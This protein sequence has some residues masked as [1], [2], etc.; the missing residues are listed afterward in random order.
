LKKI[1]FFIYLLASLQS[2]S[3]N[4]T[5]GSVYNFDVGD[6]IVTAYAPY[7][8]GSGKP[9]EF[10]YRVFTHKS[11]SLNQDSVY[12]TTKEIKVNII[13]GNVPFIYTSTTTTRSFFV[14]HLSASAITYTFTS[15]SCNSASDT[16]FTNSCGFNIREQSNQIKYECA[17][18][19]NYYEYTF[20]EGIG[21]FYKNYIGSQHGGWQN[22]FVSAHKVNGPSCGPVGS[23]PTGITKWQKPDHKINLYPNPAKD[24]FA[25]DLDEKG[26]FTIYDA[27]GNKVSNGN[28]E[29]G[30]NKMDVTVLSPGIYNVVCFSK[31]NIY[32]NKLVKE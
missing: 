4:F 22:Y 28:L 29:R 12:Y 14:T 9:P 20:I 7:Q 31:N 2:Y 27:R 21:D 16:T 8:T 10:T 26:T 32:T 13:P 11:F 3:Q 6:T 30:K 18:E 24:E 1:L 25:V 19:P 5:Y 17:F 15:D 23:I